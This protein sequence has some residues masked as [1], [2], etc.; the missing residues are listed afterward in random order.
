MHTT[1]R[2]WYAA[3]PVGALFLLVA[4]AAP[5]RA[6]PSFARQTKLPCSACHTQFPELNAFGRVF[7]LNGFTLRMIE[8]I[9][10]NNPSGH[11]DLAIN[12]MPLPAVMFQASETYTGKP[13][14]GT[15]NGNVLFPDQLSVFLAGAITPK[16]G[17]F[18]QVTYDPASGGV[19]LDNTSVRYATP[20]TLAGKPGVFGLTLNNNPTMQ[21]VWNSTPAWGFPY[22]GSAVAPVP[23]AAT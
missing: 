19:G 6:I 14:P 21:D 12:L 13:Q 3:A 17:A 18:I 1:A 23:G 7:K 2:R 10:A 5:L 20:I 4:G 9:E 11:Q 15:T 16:V 8:A 22:V